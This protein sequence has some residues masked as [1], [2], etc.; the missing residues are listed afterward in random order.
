MFPLL[1][2]Y[3]CEY[4]SQQK[5]AAHID[6]PCSFLIQDSICSLW[7]VAC[8]FSFDCVSLAVCFHT[9]GLRQADASQN[10]AWVSD[11]H[12]V[13]NRGT[14]RVTL[15]GSSTTR[16]CEHRRYYDKFLHATPFE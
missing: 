4:M 5:R 8:D 14:S 10:T 9:H 12:R 11:F 6:W 3:L 13:H 16:V 7:H 15:L 1:Y 2:K